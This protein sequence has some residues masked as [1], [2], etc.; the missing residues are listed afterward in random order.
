MSVYRREWIDPKTGRKRVSAY[1]YIDVTVNGVRHQRRTRPATKVKAIAEK[2][3]ARLIAGVATPD[4]ERGR[5]KEILDR[6]E[7]HLETH[8]PST[9]AKAKSRMKLLRERFAALPVERMTVERA[10][11]L[12]KALK[13]KGSSPSTI[14]GH[15]ILLKAAFNR[16]RREGLV[17]EHP[18]C[19]LEIPYKAPERHIVWTLEEIAALRASLP[20]WAA[21]VVAVLVTT[22]LRVGDALALRWES[23]QGDRLRLLMQKTG[24]PLEIPLSAAAQETFKTI[25]RST[26]GFVFPAGRATKANPTPK[27][28]HKR[29]RAFLRCVINA[30]T[31]GTIPEG[32]TVHDL[33]RTFAQTR[34][35]AGIDDRTIAALLGQTTTRIVSRYTEVEMS[36]LRAAVEAS[37]PAPR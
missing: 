18:I 29:Y 10:D 11:D 28:T 16:A 13:A 23:V 1:F 14:G 30:R 12:V 31:A 35:R 3:E 37:P 36:A 32:K 20:R 2:E 5:V 7:K 26:S 21:D 6:Y 24:E 33:R 34:K 4:P 15:L 22:G 19:R 27:A 8:S 9:L 17:G 25:P